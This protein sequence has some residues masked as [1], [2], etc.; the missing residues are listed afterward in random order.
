MTRE[1]VMALIH[2]DLII[3]AFGILNVGAQLPQTKKMLI[4]RSSEGLSVGMIFI[5]LLT[6]IALSING[7]FMHDAVQAW[8]LGLSAVVSVVNILLY[9]KYRP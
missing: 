7:Y 8:T 9:F 2:W 6:Q 3:L 4:D 1:E 5:Y